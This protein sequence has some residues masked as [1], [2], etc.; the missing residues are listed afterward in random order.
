[1]EKKLKVMEFERKQKLLDYVNLNSDKL[2]V[3]SITS[4]QE[5]FFYKHFLWYYDKQGITINKVDTKHRITSEYI[6]PYYFKIKTVANKVLE[7]HKII[8]DNY[9]HGYR[10]FIVLYLVIVS[11][12]GSINFLSNPTSVTDLLFG[13]I[14]LA[15][16]Y[17]LFVAMIGKKGLYISDNKFYRGIAIADK[18]LLKEKVDIVNFSEFTHKKKEKTDLPWFLEYT[19]L[20]FFSKHHKCSVYLEKLILKKKNINLIFR[21]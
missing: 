19:S 3:L 2:H 7:K 12:F 4:S 11:F 16:T 9:L 8:L 13:L 5:F 18:F 14:F 15:T 6:K 21:H 20:G 17:I 10:K 1:M